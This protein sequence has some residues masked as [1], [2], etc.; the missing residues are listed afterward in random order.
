MGVHEGVEEFLR[1]REALCSAPCNCALH[2]TTP[3]FL[4]GKERTNFFQQNVAMYFD[5]DFGFRIAKRR[6][7]MML[8]LV[9]FAIHR[10]EARPEWKAR[11]LRLCGF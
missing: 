6:E 10:V 5:A 9:Y 3:Y 7:V 8:R 1:R 11:N 2:D 4:L